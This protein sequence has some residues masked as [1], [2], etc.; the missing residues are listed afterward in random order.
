MKKINYFNNPEYFLL[1]LFG[2]LYYIFVLYDNHTSLN[3]NYQYYLYDYNYGF[4]KRG[5]I[6]S[7]LN[8]LPISIS[9]HVF[10][11]IA[12]LLIIILGIFLVSIIDYINFKN[13]FYGYF[14]VC[15]LIICPALLK[16]LW[17]DIG[18]LDIFGISYS[19]LFLYPFKK[20]I[21]NIIL[22]LS[23]LTLFIHE[24]F[25][26]LWLP[27]YYIC[28]YIKNN[29][30]LT[31][32]TI[33][34]SVFF[35]ISSLIL[36]FLILKYGKLDVDFYTYQ[37]YIQNKTKD[38]V[39]LENTVITDKLYNQ[40]YS[41]F[42]L[43][44]THIK[45]W[46]LGIINLF[47]FAYIINLYCSFFKICFYKYKI[48]FIPLIFSFL[49]FFLGCDALRWFSNMCFSLYILLICI[50]VTNKE[51]INNKEDIKINSNDA[52]YMI[53]ILLVMLPFRKLGVLW[54]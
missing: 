31:K 26:L 47:S 32:L 49:M 28:W 12:T 30:N 48:I 23:P 9:E 17:Y 22:I 25:F 24:G 11:S 3:F 43:N 4:I 42:I 29:M 36:L 50:L 18:R 44:F 34:Y 2:L 1:L 52:Y 8:F 45:F 46:F 14:L 15:F 5:L 39:S 21:L 13:K 54:G 6:G 20:K 10:V 27:T 53:F 19:L 51:S 37:H 40:M 16:N 41:S 38:I 35:I 7:L 33:Y